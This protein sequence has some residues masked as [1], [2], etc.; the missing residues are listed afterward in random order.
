MRFSLS[1]WQTQENNSTRPLF[2]M[3]SDR[4]MVVAH[5]C[6]KLDELSPPEPLGMFIA[7]S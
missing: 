4:T 1:V 2:P 3:I 7:V 6:H 5:V